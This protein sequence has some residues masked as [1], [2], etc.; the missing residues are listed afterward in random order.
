MKVGDLV[1]IPWPDDHDVWHKSWHDLFDQIGV[2][3]KIQLPDNKII[4]S[5]RIDVYFFTDGNYH[6]VCESWLEVIKE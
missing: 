6:N 3:V 5:T 4:H 1:T 2:V